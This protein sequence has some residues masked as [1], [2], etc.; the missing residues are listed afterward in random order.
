[1]KQQSPADLTERQTLA[2]VEDHQIGV[3]QAVGPTALVASL[4]L[5][6]QA[7]DLADPGAPMC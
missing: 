3:H 7:V 6:F 4:F 5:L 2:L 1:M